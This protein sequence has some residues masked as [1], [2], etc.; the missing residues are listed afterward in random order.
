MV[1]RE[2]KKW[3]KTVFARDN[4]TC[5]I[6][7]DNQ[8]GNLRAHHIKPYSEYPEL[9]HD[10]DNGITLCEN[11]HIKLHKKSELDIQSELQK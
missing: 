6:C 9:R 8:G 11:C 10:V 1:S 7:G 4:Y 2:Y 3:R 5:Q